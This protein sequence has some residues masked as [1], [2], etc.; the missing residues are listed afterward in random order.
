MVGG[1]PRIFDEI[2]YILDGNKGKW[3]RG[4]VIIK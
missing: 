4:A 2:D 1:I 3:E